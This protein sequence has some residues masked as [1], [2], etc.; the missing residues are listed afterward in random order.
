MP[1]EK[2]RREAQV[3]TSIRCNAKVIKVAKDVLDKYLVYVSFY[4]KIICL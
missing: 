3:L 2:V 1:K 4:F